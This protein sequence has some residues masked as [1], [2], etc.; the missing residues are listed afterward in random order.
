M[1]LEANTDTHLAISRIGIYNCNSI[2]VGPQVWPKHL[3]LY[4]VTVFGITLILAYTLS[5]EFVER[6][7][8]VILQGGLTVLTAVSAHHAV[9]TGPTQY[10]LL[11]FLPCAGRPSWP[12]PLHVRHC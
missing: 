4:F 9:H 7:L 3:D 8:Q 1:P 5:R 11:M 2:H 10:Y 6:W 12:P